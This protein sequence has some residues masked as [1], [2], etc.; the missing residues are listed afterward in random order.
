MSY[1]YSTLQRDGAGGR[2]YSSRQS[3]VTVLPART[4]AHGHQAVATPIAQP[5]SPPPAAPAWQFT[6][7]S[8]GQGAAA[9]IGPEAAGRLAL[10]EAAIT[11]QIGGVRPI[12]DRAIV[13]TLWLVHDLTVPL[14]LAPQ[15]LA[16]LPRGATGTGNQPGAVFTLD[17]N[18]ATYSQASNTLSVSVSPGAFT[19]GD[20]GAWTLSGPLDNRSNQAYHPM[21]VLGPSAM[22]DSNATLPSGTVA[23]ILT[24]MFM[25]PATV[26]PELNLR[27]Q[28]AQRLTAV[29]R[30]VL[31]AGAVEFLAASRFTRAAVT[32]EGPVR[33]TPLLMPTRQTCFLM[34]LRPD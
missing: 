19:P 3:Q 27:S 32:L 13:P 14:D 18:P 15:D 17:G 33:T 29:T 8:Q 11:A 26:H 9:Q 5:A 34:A 20:G 31:S 28:F 24:D 7:S 6:L 23:R 21:A 25:R 4:G 1:T 30:D 16:A 10:A 12:R 22:A 2:V